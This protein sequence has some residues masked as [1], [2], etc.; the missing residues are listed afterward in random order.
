M[1]ETQPITALMRSMW[2]RQAERGD[3][4]TKVYAIVSLG[5]EQ[6]KGYVIGWAI[7]RKSAEA[8]LSKRGNPEAW[9]I[10]TVTPEVTP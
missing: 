8:D 5:V 6:P 3:K 2:K 1:S 4:P 7:R 10:V 9:R